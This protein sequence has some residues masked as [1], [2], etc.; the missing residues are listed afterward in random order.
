MCVFYYVQGYSK[1][2]PSIVIIFHYD[3]FLFLLKMCLLFTM[4][5]V[6]LKC[7]LLP[8]SGASPSG[9]TVQGGSVAPLSRRDVSSTP[10]TTASAPPRVPHVQLHRKI[11][12]IIRN[13]GASKDFYRRLPEKLCDA[14]KLSVPRNAETCWNGTAL[15]M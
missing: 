1:K 11:A 9:V 10:S 4:F 14:Q 7:G 13:L 15:G 6:I 3:M 5:Q 8:T 2:R 12:T